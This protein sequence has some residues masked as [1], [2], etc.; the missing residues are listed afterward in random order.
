MEYND[1]VKCHTRFYVLLRVSFR[2]YISVSWVAGCHKK[3]VYINI[4]NYYNIP[5]KSIAAI[6]W[7]MYLKMKLSVIDDIRVKLTSISNLYEIQSFVKFILRHPFFRLSTLCIARS[8]FKHPFKAKYII[9][10]LTK[11]HL[12]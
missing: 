9:L 7:C 6:L 11:C 8:V 5:W 10:H 4:S 2:T 12:L 1:E 3:Q